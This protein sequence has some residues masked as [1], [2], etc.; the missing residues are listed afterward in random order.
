M[1]TV[2]KNPYNELIINNACKIENTLP[3][4][5]QWSILS[6]DINYVQ[7][8]KNPQNFHSMTLRPVKFNRIVKDTKDRNANESLLEVNL[9]DILDRLKE[10]YLDRYEGITSEIA[11]TTR[12]DENSDLRTTYLGRIN[13]TH[14]KNLIVEE[15][16][17]IS[18][19]RLHSRQITG[20]NRM[21]DTIR[22]RS[23]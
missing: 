11:D 2:E 23:K 22:H 14:E 20:W 15:K 10:E 4:I 8:S 1:I 3:Q 19:V 12:F 18:K 7:Y 9:V 6:N 13:M 17:S 21:P 16:F 5:E